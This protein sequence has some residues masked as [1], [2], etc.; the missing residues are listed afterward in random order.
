MITRSIENRVYSITAN[1]TG[2]EER[3]GT[4]LHYI[5]KSQIISTSGTVLTRSGEEEAQVGEAEIDPAL[6]RNKQILD[7]N[8]LFQDRRPEFYRSLAKDRGPLTPHDR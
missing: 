4:R 2:T 3:G 8:H 7:Y 1:R 5:G 6:S